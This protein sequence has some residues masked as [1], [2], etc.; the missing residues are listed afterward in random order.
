MAL[1]SANSM[2]VEFCLAN[3]ARNVV[4]QAIVWEKRLD[5]TTTWHA[6]GKLRNRI[7]SLIYSFLTNPCPCGI[8][9]IV[10]CR[11]DFLGTCQP[12]WNF[13]EYLK[14]HAHATF[15]RYS[16]EMLTQHQWRFERITQ[17]VYF[18]HG[19]KV[20]YRY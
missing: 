8:C 15:G 20:T 5:S 2:Q 4:K 1:S 18:P 10:K 14:E 12:L 3:R 13:V 16:K 9:R 17:S 11:R 7:R 6:M 19:V